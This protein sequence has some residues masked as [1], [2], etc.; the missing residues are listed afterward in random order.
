MNITPK[1]EAV[2]KPWGSYITFTQNEPS[3]VKLLYI[4]KGEAFSLQ[5]HSHREEFWKVLQGNPSIII[6]EDTILAKP[7]D[8]FLITQG[9]NHRVTAPE[10][11]VVILEISKGEFDEDDITRIEDKY[12]RS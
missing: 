2:I 8:E 6:G 11:D 1:R 9:T 3:T 4:T 7:D 5:F 10:N 12:G